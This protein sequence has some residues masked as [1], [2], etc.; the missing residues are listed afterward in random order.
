MRRD[1]GPVRPDRSP[2]RRAGGREGGAARGVVAAVAP[3][4]VAERHRRARGDRQVRV[5]DVDD[6]MAWLGILLPSVLAHAAHDRLTTM[7]RRIRST[8]DA[9]QPGAEPT[10]GRRRRRVGQAVPRR[11]RDAHPHRHVRAHRADAPLPPTTGPALPIPRLPDARP[12]V[13]HRP[14]PRPRSGR[15]HRRR[16]RHKV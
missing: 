2:D 12:S 3:R 16:Q 14:Q 13:R 10:E 4:T 5:T 15:P 8:G 7:A 6:G 11:T 1:R 9:A